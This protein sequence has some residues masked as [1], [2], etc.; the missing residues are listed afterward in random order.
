[1]DPKTLLAPEN[2]IGYAA[3]FWFIE[4]FKVLGFS[5][6]AGPMNLWYAGGILAAILSVFGKGNSK[7]VGN[8]IA[9]SLPFAIALGVNFGIIP[10]LFVQVAYYQFFYPATILMAWPWFAVFWMVT[11]AYFGVYLHRLSIEG[12]LKRSF[13]AFSG[14]VSALLLIVVGFL[15]ANAF[16]LMTNVGGWWSVFK[17]ANVAG[18]ATGLATNSADPTLIPRWLFMFGMALTTTAVYVAIDTAYLSGRESDDYRRYASKFAGALYTVGL[19]WFV[20]F[21]YWYIFGTR[22]DAF[23][24]AMKN[25]IM[26][27]VFPLAAVSPGLPWLLLLLQRGGA[28]KR[29]AWLAGVAQFGVIALNAVSRQWQQNRELAPYADLASR[30]MD[31]QWSALVVFLLVFVIGVA[32]IYWMLRK[33]VQVN[34]KEG[35]AGSKA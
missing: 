13:G 33:I 34:R 4:L 32:I 1:M 25:P 23:A 11:V 9:R 28:T 19:L 22:P 10:L 14:W 17:K 29:M 26:R 6:H 30:R 7:T 16:T 5:L 18:A 20:G 12:K 31:P 2:P 21:G 35:S 15:F 8:H 27:I 3:P 24:E